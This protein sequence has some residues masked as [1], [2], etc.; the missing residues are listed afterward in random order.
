MPGQPLSHAAPVAAVAPG[1]RRGLDAGAMLTVYLVLLFAIPSNLT[2]GALAALGR[3]SLLWGLLLFVWWALSRLQPPSA[4]VRTVAQ[5]VRL[6]LGALIVVALV[7]LAAAMLRGQPADQISPALTAIIRLLSWSGVAL[8][9]MDGLTTMREISRMLRRL[10]V[11]GALLA[12]LGIAQFATGQTLL[13]V[14]AVLPGITVEEGGVDARGAFTRS[15]GTATHPLEYATAL[16]AI[17]PLA[18]AGAIS[19]GFRRS[20]SGQPLLWWIP[21]ALI[22]LSALLAVSRSAIIGVAVAVVAMI[23]GIPRR[24]RATVVAGGFALAVVA[25]VAVPGLFGTMVGLFAGIGSD[26]S[27]TSRVGGLDRAGEFISTSPVFGNGLGTFLPRYYFFDN[28]WALMAVELGVLGLLALAALIAAGIWSAWH[29][30]KVSGEDD[31]LLAGRALTA[32]LIAVAV[33]FGFF[34]GLQF[35]IAAGLPFLLIG[36]ACALRTVGQVDARLVRG[37]QRA[38]R[39]EA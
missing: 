21:V 31:V 9:A 3:P 35:P 30:G 23:P 38:A 37:R 26:S 29:A 20:G 11:A 39:A 8:V 15:S 14:F 5:P 1:R 2:I 18:I 13:D 32:S 10:V 22:G 33:L 24:H 16:S 4:A 25:V 27:T 17:L 34:D 12:A 6:A 36:L 28:Q 7:S 19:R